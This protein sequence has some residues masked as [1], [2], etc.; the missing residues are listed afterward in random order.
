MTCWA[1][2]FNFGLFYF[3]WGESRALYIA[4]QK[5]FP[6]CWIIAF[7]IRGISMQTLSSPFLSRLKV[8]K[9]LLLQHRFS[10]FQFCENFRCIKKGNCGVFLCLLF[11]CV[12]DSHSPS[13]LSSLSSPRG[14]KPA[15]FPI[16]SSPVASTTT[17]T[18]VAGKRGGVGKRIL[19]SSNS[20]RNEG[21][22]EGRN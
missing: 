6:L 5:L 14:K 2:Q 16:F 17:T 3:F 9:L 21:G 11:L 19:L 20:G 18:T 12:P 10:P 7:G 1:P 13:P 4:L 22:R 8:K 15:E